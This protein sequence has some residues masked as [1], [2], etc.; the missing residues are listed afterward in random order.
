MSKAMVEPQPKRS[1]PT[2]DGVYSDA[3]LLLAARLYY[4]DGILQNQIAKMVG[5]SQAKVSRM[6]AVARDRGLVRITVP[7]YEPRER[8]LEAELVS[9]Y[10]L[11]MAIVVRKVAG[12]SVADLRNTLGYF[13]GPIVAATLAPYGT[14]AVAGGRTLQSLT[15]AMS[16]GPGPIRPVVVQAMGNVDSTPGSYDASEIARTLAQ[17][18]GGVYLTLNT[19]AFAPT[20]A[21]GKQL[22]ELKDTRD[23]FERL[24]AAETA[25]VGVGNLQNSVFI[26]RNI[27]QQKDIQELHRAGAVGEILGRF[28]DENGVECQ[29]SYRQRVLSLPLEKLRAIPNVVAAIAGSDRTAAI[30]GALRGGILK[31]I[32]IDDD[33]AR[34]LLAG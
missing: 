6:L 16:R 12:Q 21:V 17:P 7:E 25:L 1:T 33:G 19:P 8:E 10:Q 14:L 20:A 32:V 13:A 5:V 4:V 2:G 29:T 28:Y 24:A 34:S 27:L 30:R 9:A 11:K 23:V 3:Q 26:E 15:D 22:L 18:W 31:S